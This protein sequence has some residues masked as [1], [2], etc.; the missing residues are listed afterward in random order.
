MAIIKRQTKASV[1]KGKK[2]P[3]TLLECKMV[4][5]LWK[6]IRQFLTKSKIELTHNAVILL[7]TYATQQK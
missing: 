3:H 1:N 5:P 4:Q 7:L 2:N 6:T